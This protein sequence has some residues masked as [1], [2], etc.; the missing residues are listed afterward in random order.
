M[1]MN[2]EYLDE[3][4]TD[5]SAEPDTEGGGNY[6]LADVWLVKRAKLK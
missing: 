4:V 5:K 2:I 1:M 3:M 6:A